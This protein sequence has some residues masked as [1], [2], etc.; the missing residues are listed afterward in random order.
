MIIYYVDEAGCTGALPSATSP[1]QPVFALA[2]VLIRQ[3]D[4]RSLT[5]SFIDLKE[6]FYPRRLASNRDHL[7]WMNVEIKGADLRRA[8]RENNRDQQR[9]AFGFM[10]KFL[11]LLT[12]HNARV[13]GRVYVKGIARPFVGRSVYTSAVQN[14]SNDFQRYLADTQETGLLVLDSRHKQSNANVSHSVFT[15]K[16]RAAGDAYDRLLEM[17]L[18]GHSDNHAGIQ[19][20]DLICSAFLFPMATYAYCMG[21]V[22]NIHV[23]MRYELLR[24]RYGGAIKQFQYRYQDMDGRWRG[25]ITVNDQIG[26]ENG[27]LLFGPHR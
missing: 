14:I 24:K 15:Q 3:N 27:A 13:I 23:H 5:R 21:H 20:A 1:I 6:R 9:H 11:D 4:I 17:P 16:F 18:F 25:G 8:I 12:Q 2:G 19:C 22:N 26:H 10:D 7:D